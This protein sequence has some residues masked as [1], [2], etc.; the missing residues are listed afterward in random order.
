MSATNGAKMYNS[1]LSKPE[2]QPDDWGYSFE[3]RT[4]HVWDGVI[5]LCLLEDHKA[6][7]EALQLPHGGEQRDRLTEAIRENNLR[8]Q[9]EGQ[10]EWD[11]YCELC[12]RFF[13]DEDGILCK[14]N[15]FSDL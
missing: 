6:R 4:E 8:F 14:S 12:M 3:L 11:H 1:C 10:P 15:W 5:L 7:G 13:E 2:C 9:R